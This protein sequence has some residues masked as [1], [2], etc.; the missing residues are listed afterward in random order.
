MKAMMEII[1]IPALGPSESSAA[2]R[3][4]IRTLPPTDTVRTDAGDRAH[5]DAGAEPF[6]SQPLGLTILLVK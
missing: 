1:T 4:T 5:R 3:R 2:R 6:V